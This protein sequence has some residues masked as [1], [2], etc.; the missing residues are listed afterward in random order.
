MNPGLSDSKQ[1]DILGYKLNKL[2]QN[3]IFITLRD[4]DKLE[5]NEGKFFEGVS[6]QL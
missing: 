1:K 4:S 6:L 3:D 2:N 5:E